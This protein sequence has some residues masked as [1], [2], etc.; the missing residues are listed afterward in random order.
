VA[1]FSTQ[2]TYRSTDQRGRISCAQPLVDLL[3]PVEY[4]DTDRPDVERPTLYVLELP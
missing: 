3:S 2:A 1:E 4:R